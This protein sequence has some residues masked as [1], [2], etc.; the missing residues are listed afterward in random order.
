MKE[1]LETTGACGGDGEF[2]LDISRS[3][4]TKFEGVMACS[5]RSGRPREIIFS[6]E[7][8]AWMSI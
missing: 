5:S 8:T 4:F 3:S 6:S 1:L 7:T 2:S